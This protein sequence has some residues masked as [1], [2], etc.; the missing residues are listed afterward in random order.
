M[1]KSEKQEASSTSLQK[2]LLSSTRIVQ[3]LPARTRTKKGA[4]PHPELG[5]NDS[6]EECTI[7]KEE[8]S[9]TGF[10][11]ESQHASHCR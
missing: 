8:S 3:L 9:K 5:K 10:K 11:H 1:S 2:E 4:L 6:V 7:L